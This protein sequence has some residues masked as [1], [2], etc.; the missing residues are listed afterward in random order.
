MMEKLTTDTEFLVF[1]S[2]WEPLPLVLD[3]YQSLET[4]QE[5]LEIYGISKDR[6]FDEPGGSEG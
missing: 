6:R 1:E 3:Y 2:D 5:I 4:H